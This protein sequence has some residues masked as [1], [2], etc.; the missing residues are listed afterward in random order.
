MNEETRMLAAA[1][2]WA[3]NHLEVGHQD[4]HDQVI[5]TLDRV[6]K[7]REPTVADMKRFREMYPTRSS[8]KRK[9]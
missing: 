5:E 2:L 8:R 4:V 6:L 3:R 1:L 7:H 9:E